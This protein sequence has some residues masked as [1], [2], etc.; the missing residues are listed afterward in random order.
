MNLD[1]GKRQEKKSEEIELRTVEEYLIW[2]LE[3]RGGV[4]RSGVA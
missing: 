2:Q 4:Y 3:K 1:E